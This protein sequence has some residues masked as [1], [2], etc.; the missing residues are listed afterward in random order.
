MKQGETSK[1]DCTLELS[2]ENLIGLA[3]GS[4]DP[5]KLYMDGLLKIGG[6]IMASQKL[7]FL[8]KIDPP[9]PGSAETVPESSLDAPVSVARE[10]CASK[11]FAALSK[12]LEGEVLAQAANI[13]FVISEPD[14]SWNIRLGEEP[15]VSEGGSGEAGV[16][17]HITDE[18]LEDLAKEASPQDLFQ[19]GLTLYL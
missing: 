4:A 17:V 7:D 1:V 9:V 14:S 10:A 3:T 19:R 2:T 12:K 11:V 6:D 18:H 16:T 8:K 13:Q 5:M 15:S